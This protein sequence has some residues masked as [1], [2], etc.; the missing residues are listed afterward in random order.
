MMFQATSTW[1]RP[2]H[3]PHVQASGG[4]ANGSLHQDYTELPGSA[5]N[6]LGAAAYLEADRM[7]ACVLT[8]DTLRTQFAVVRRRSGSPVTDRPYEA[9]HVDR[10]ALRALPEHTPTP[11]TDIESSTTWTR[12][13]PTSAR[14]SRP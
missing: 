5:L 10:A 1:L 11:I 8:R 13:R 9:S 6:V 7:R 4:T 14:P 3:F 12:Q 2:D